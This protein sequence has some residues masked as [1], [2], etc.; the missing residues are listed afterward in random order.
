MF[1]NL[2]SRIGLVLVFFLLMIALISFLGYRSIQQFSRASQAIMEDNFQSIRYAEAMQRHFSQIHEFHVGNVFAEKKPN[3]ANFK[4]NPSYQNAL[5]QFE[6]Q[7][8]LAQKNITEEKE[9]DLIINL[10]KTYRRYLVVFR[11]TYNTSTQNQDMEE[12]IRL[13]EVEFQPLQRKIR[14]QINQLH[15]INMQAIAQKTS[16]TQ[17]NGNSISFYLGLIGTITL[18]VNILLMIFLPSYLTK[19]LNELN[20]GIQ[21]IIGGNYDQEL[22]VKFHQQ[23]E[24][25]KLANSFNE[26]VDKLQNYDVPQ[27]AGLKQERQRIETLVQLIDKATIILD[28]HQKILH[29]NPQALDLLDIS[30]KDVIGTPIFRWANENELASKM[31][32]DWA[33]DTS[34]NPTH[35][36]HQIETFIIHQNGKEETYQKLTAEIKCSSETEPELVGYAIILAKISE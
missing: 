33:G 36:Q 4:P 12:N 27:L 35:H 17:E 29:I 20:A 6:A 22:T 25:G 34:N 32:N 30:D 21:E 15:D 16:Y 8:L 5:L 3:E 28:E 24:V 7:L 19:P 31:M 13:A 1:Q 18:I 9:Q 14:E 23:D 11:E 2:E 10:Q 26:L